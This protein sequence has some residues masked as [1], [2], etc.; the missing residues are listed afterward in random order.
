MAAEVQQLTGT[1]HL[2]ANL[3]R[4][5]RFGLDLYQCEFMWEETQVGELID[6]LSTGFDD[7]FDESHSA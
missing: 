6:D 7:E 2:V 5:N 1:A 4:N 3:L